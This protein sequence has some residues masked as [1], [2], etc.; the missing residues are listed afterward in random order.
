MFE[1]SK[2]TLY[3]NV[4]GSGRVA[5]GA[6]DDFDLKITRESN[7]LFVKICPKR[8]MELVHAEIA[9]DYSFQKETSVLANGYQSWSLTKEWKRDELQKGIRFPVNKIKFGREI[10]AINGAY[11]FKT[12]PKTAGFFHG[13]SFGYV[14]NGFTHEFIGSLNERSGWTILNFDFNKNL[15]T[16][17][18]DVERKTIKGDFTL[19][20][21]A[22]FNGSYDEVFDAYFKTLDVS[23][24]RVNHTTGY[25]SWYNY[26]TK[27]DDTTYIVDGR[28]ELDKFFETF[29]LDKDEAA[30]FDSQ[31]VSGWI[32]AEIGEIPKKAQT[33][34]YKNL[35]IIVNRL[36]QRKILDVKVIVN[37]VEE[38]EDDI[39]KPSLFEKVSERIA[40]KQENKQDDNE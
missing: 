29:G 33:F 34:N 35:T 38:N 27:I 26:F 21:V 12:Y 16:L 3:Y 15:I 14:R 25:T 11:N 7:R 40:E 4:G 2:L 5:N 9:T 20:D 19:F 1:T 30:D 10:A 6:N 23:K 32:I 24:C 22:F 13:Y 37:P 28:A 36:T 31:T 18:K 39:E 8:E 17:E